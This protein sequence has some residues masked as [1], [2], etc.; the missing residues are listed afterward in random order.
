[1]FS[2]S[3]LDKEIRGH[4]EG[5]LRLKRTTA[6]EEI[7]QAVLLNHRLPA[8]PGVWDSDS[9]KEFF[10]FAAYD[11]VRD[12]VRKILGEFRER[13]ESAAGATQLGFEYLQQGYL[14]EHRG[15]HPLTT[16]RR[17]LGLTLEAFA[18]LAG[19]TKPTIWRIEAGVLHPAPPLMRRLIAVTA[20]EI[21][22]EL[23]LEGAKEP[24]KRQRI[25]HLE[26]MTRE[27]AITKIIELLAMAAG[28]EA[29]ADELKRYFGITDA[30]IE[31]RKAGSGPEDAAG[32]AA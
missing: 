1:M 13:S 26:K 4:I 14:I 28:C 32:Q 25:V 3:D 18:K 5:A 21:T 20:G 2:R 6:P 30:E 9:D 10:W 8:G 11:N 23:L 29:H 15:E 17:R 27:D 22:P 31:A 12:R 7:C 16:Y 19:T 24:Q